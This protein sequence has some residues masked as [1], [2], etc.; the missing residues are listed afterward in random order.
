MIL[1]VNG[2]VYFHDIIYYIIVLYFIYYDIGDY[3]IVWKVF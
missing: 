3:G 1:I 2:I